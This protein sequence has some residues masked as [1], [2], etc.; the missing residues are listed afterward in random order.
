MSYYDESGQ[1]PFLGKAEIS[2]KVNEVL[3]E[4]W[5]GIFPVN[6]ESVCDCLG[7]SLFPVAGLSKK[8]NV[9]AFVSSSFRIL[10]VDEKS[11]RNESYRYR[12]SV[13]HELGHLVL[14][15][16]YYSSRIE[17]F[18]DW[19]GLSP[20]ADNSYVEF[21]ANYFAGNL[22]VPEIELIKF[23]D[24]GFSGNFEKNCWKA[25]HKEFKD[26][27]CDAKKFFKVS[28][29]VVA[30]RMQDVFLGAEAFDEIKL[31]IQGA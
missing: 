12:F 9:D 24:R 17:S 6:L 15:R 14:H 28:D 31:T 25:T 2:D 29:Q 30:R 8:Y 18:E 7:I 19:L 23:M 16:E 13:A 4:C 10:Y 26:K 5:N 27:L 22:L 21:Q 1:I 20:H 3:D 11:Y